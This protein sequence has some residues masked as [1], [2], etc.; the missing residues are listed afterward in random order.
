M[1]IELRQLKTLLALRDTG[2][3]VKAAERLCLTQSALS[4]QI[5]ELEC[6]LG[7]SVFIRKSRP[8]RFTEPGQRLLSL[9]QEVVAAIGVAQRD[10]HKLVHGE[11]GRLFMAIECHSC[12]NWLMPTLDTYRALWPQVE[13]DFSAGFTFEPLPALQNGDVDLVITT[14]PRPL[15][16]VVYEP[17]FVCEMQLAVSPRHRLA[18]QEFIT[19]QDL[20]GEQLITYPVDH[21][22]LDIFTEFLQPAGVAPHSVRATELT[23]M[24]VQ[25]VASQ[26]GV[27]CLP[28]WVL[29]EYTLQGQ[30]VAKRLGE[31]G[32][33]TCVQ[34]ALREE[35]LAKPFAQDFIAQAR[36][37]C[38]INLRGIREP[39]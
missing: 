33:W 19:P 14:D 5:K 31:Q 28:N 3:L 10:L 25:M 11:A 7:Q 36:E 18:A 20:A 29:D 24:M 34:M 22:R 17:L 32:L 39:D 26:R 15:K 2:T 37:H 12:F 8:L 4:H 13:L 6:Q 16:G 30:L 35:T 9:A 21:Q 38:F 1:N 23:V 27:C